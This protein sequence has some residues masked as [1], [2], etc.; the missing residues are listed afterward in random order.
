LTQAVILA[1]GKGTRLAERLNGLPKPLVDVCG[2]P[3]LERQILL[4]KA[5]GFS[6]ILVLVSHEAAKIV[7]FCASR[8]NWGLDVECI[9]DGEPRGTAGAVL[10]ILD[11]LDEE[12]LVLYGDTMLDVDLG[13][14]GE[15]HKSMGAGATLFLHP[16]DHP[17]DSDLVELGT[18]G[19]VVAFHPYP[20]EAGQFFH[21]LVN[22]ALYVIQRKALEPWRGLVDKLDFGKALFPKM[23]G[24][25]VKIAGYNC[26]EYIKDAGTP[27]R[28]DKVCADL[29][30]GKIERSRLSVPQPVVF[31]DRDG[32]INPD[33]VH[34]D[35]IAK[36]RLYEEAGEAVRRLNKSEYRTALVTNQPV[37]ARGGLSLA[38]LDQIHAK[39][40][41]LLGE[42]RAFLDRIYFCPHHPDKGFE[43]EIPEL[44]FVCDCRKPATGMIEKARAELNADLSRSWMVG[45]TST[46]MQLAANA[47][48]KSIFVQT[49]YSGVDDKYPARASFI[50][51]DLA[52]AVAFILDDYP[53]LEE[54]AKR[55]AA[56]LEPGG[57]VYIGGALASGKS[58]VASALAIALGQREI[59]VGVFSLDQRVKKRI[60][61]ILKRSASLTPGNGETPIEV[62]VRVAKS[63]R[64]VMREKVPIGH[65]M[66]FEGLRAPMMSQRKPGVVI[67]VEAPE[68]LRRDR[69]LKEA[70]I[71]GRDE[72]MAIAFFEFVETQTKPINAGARALAQETLDISP[73]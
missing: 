66:I 30:S 71:R 24:A 73:R 68:V 55:V 72:T 9:D 67:Y 59:G 50:L 17:Q 34:L 16:N 12:F 33:M 6:K 65:V 49:T 70:R 15:F 38:G 11:R 4:C 25:G 29:E 44:K 69:F 8:D 63:E 18:G 23:L 10:A 46:D 19:F 58:V 3:L 52:E 61:K 39:M 5:H 21:N 2:V 37:V 1:G 27:E 13:R 43:G 40:E 22:A 64:Q 41:T 60:F 14:F 56:K 51:P 42:H 54:W 20:H 48:V 26:P 31:L 47:K 32:V 36:Y 7:E 28:L 57:R 35:S 53:R 62:D 45:D